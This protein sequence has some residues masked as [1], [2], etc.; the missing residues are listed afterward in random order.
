MEVPQG[1]RALVEKQMREEGLSLR[2]V[3]QR[4]GLSPSF[5][6]RIL[7]GERGLPTNEVLLDLAQALEVDP[8]A[9]LLVQAE[10]IP[11]RSM[12]E[13]SDQER[14]LVLKSIQSLVASSRRRPE[15]RT[16]K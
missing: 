7:S 5:L 3:A 16:A 12:G 10:R 11:T 13:L 14:R 2:T 15:K 8:P 4:A 6:S 9:L 1:F